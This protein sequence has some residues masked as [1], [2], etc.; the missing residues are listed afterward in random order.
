MSDE[1]EELALILV[2]AQRSRYSIAPRTTTE[3]CSESCWAEVDAILA[4]GYRKPRQVTTVEELDALPDGSII[5][6]A[7]GLCR[8]GLRTMGSGNVWR[9]MGPAQVLRSMEIALPATVLHVGGAA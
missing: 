5:L 9:A 3:H 6:D 8:E 2:N 4:A 7:R 1:R